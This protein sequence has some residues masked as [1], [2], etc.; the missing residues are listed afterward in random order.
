MPA[1]G[2]LPTKPE[3]PIP[4]CHHSATRTLPSQLIW[5]VGGPSMKLDILKGFLKILHYAYT[6]MVLSFCSFVAA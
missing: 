5:C 6:N 3:Q 4:A 1:A 2:S